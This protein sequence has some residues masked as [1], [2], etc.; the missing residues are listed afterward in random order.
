MGWGSLTLVTDQDLGAIEPQ[1]IAAD[2][3]WGKTAWPEARAEAKRE[4][5]ILIESAF[6][7][8]VKNAADR[9]LDRHAPDLVYSYISSAYADIT[10]NAS[11]DTEDD[12]NLTAIFVNTANKLYIGADY[13]FDGLSVL[14]KDALNA[15]ASVLTVK[16]SA[17]AGFTAMPNAA[18]GTAVSGKVFAQTGRITWPVI[19]GDWK[20]QR[21][22]PSG[23]EL[24]WIELTVGTALSSGS[25]TAAQI[26]CIRPPDGLKR[27]AQLLA[28]AYIL[29]GLERQAAKPADWTE[30]AQFYRDHGLA[31][32][33]LLKE[34][35]G[36]PVD[37]NRDN[38]VTAAEIIETR[39][40]RLGRA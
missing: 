33:Q 38:V 40:V 21:L 25:A 5:K 20:R 35:G 22:G 2:R 14:M 26:L 31:L 10:A 12:V 24:F 17:A 30:K 15:V 29:N 36:I 37:V 4:L 16:Y 13:Q 8:D 9:I 27:V 11:S 6:A 23:E 18:D 1:A 28:L 3:P 7:K 32:F 19:P 39:P 34:Q